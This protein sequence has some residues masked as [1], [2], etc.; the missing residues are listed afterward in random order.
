MTNNSKE[1]KESL[2][3][4]YLAEL[5]NN[6]FEDEALC[7]IFFYK[8]INLFDAAYTSIYWDLLEYIRES[9][10]IENGK[11]NLHPNIKNILNN[12]VFQT[13]NQ[14]SKGLKN[15]YYLFSNK[16]PLP[17]FSSK[18]KALIL[19]SF[20]NQSGFPI[21]SKMVDHHWDI[22]FASWNANLRTPV[23]ALGIYYFDIIETYR[24]HY[25]Q[26][27]EINKYDVLSSLKPNLIELMNNLYNSIFDNN[28]VSDISKILSPHIIQARNYIDIYTDILENLKPGVVL[29]FNENSMS[30]RTM[31]LVSKKQGIPSITIQHGLFIGNVYRSLA[32]NKIIVWGD[33][34]KKFWMER[35]CVSD[36]V[37]PV[38]A[39]PY[40]GIDSTTKVPKSFFQ[41]KKEGG[42][43]ILFLGQ[44]PSAFIS[45]TV[46]RMTIEA[47]GNLINRLPNL[48]YYI[49]PH[50]SEN[51]TPYIK[52]GKLS[53][54]VQIIK[55]KTIIDSILHADIVITV[56]STAG[57]EAMMMGKPVVVLDL[58]E[59][60]PHAPYANVAK[61]VQK[62]DD[63]PNTINN[64]IQDNIARQKLI[65]SCKSYAESYLGR[66]DGL[67]TDRAEEIIAGM[68][69]DG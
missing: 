21:L 24:N 10:T 69:E 59:D 45:K 34:P 29:L 19:R 22:I 9:Q 57:L 16:R 23:E 47:I 53:Q 40:E 14:I 38:G 68:L 28:I 35:G 20:R 63:L 32:T 31:A 50:P 58:S 36:Q 11:I 30:E 51:F 17:H 41:E 64:L 25:A 52:L 1:I 2:F 12:S 66:A 5:E 44:N 48:N 39:Y 46:H 67:A 33:E 61:L 18:K 43:N 27:Q 42:I 8:G 56:F 54:N 37:F 3:Y 13:I 55:D 6:F 4:K 49:K 60:V 15:R 26:I 7:Q 62:S 65:K